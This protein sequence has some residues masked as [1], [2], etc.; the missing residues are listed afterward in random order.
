MKKMLKP[1]MMKTNKILIQELD[2][3]KKT[4]AM[5][6]ENRWFWIIGYFIFYQIIFVNILN[7]SYN[8]QE[9]KELH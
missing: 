6:S 8:K 1:K 5:S 7:L 4:I 2:M 3:D 9:F